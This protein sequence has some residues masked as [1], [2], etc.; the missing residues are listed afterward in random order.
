MMWRRLVIGLA[1]LSA[2]G[3]LYAQNKHE[4]PQLEPTAGQWRTW[5]ISSGKVYRVPPPPRPNATRA[6]L[7]QLA[8]L[9]QNLDDETRA[10]IAYWD[11]GSPQYRWI[12]LISN[13]L[14]AGTPTSAYPHR[15][16]TYV[17]LAMY[18][19]TV[20]AWDSKYYYGR[21]RPSEMD[22]RL[23]TAVDVPNSPSYPSEHA[24][25]A[26]AAATVLAYFLPNEAASFQSMADE[27]GW[28]RVLAGVQ[29]PSD[30]YAGADLGK[31]I[32]EQV[33]AKA[34]TDGSDAVWM[35]SVPGGPCS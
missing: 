2:A 33:I 18:D 21:L 24:A 6:E 20:A 9:T 19:A 8:D 10:L 35:G 4:D 7:R 1:C 30:Y 12:D 34:K 23:P 13:R 28:S 16:Y 25:A 29:Y 5:V 22:H 15:V 17:A 11:A 26:Q 3:P 14:L 31:K 27:A 32:G